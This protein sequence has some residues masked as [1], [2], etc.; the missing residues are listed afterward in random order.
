MEWRATRGTHPPV[1]ICEQV[2]RGD[3]EGE[4][5]HRRHTLYIAIR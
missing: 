5:T 2:R 1:R 4:Q 3:G